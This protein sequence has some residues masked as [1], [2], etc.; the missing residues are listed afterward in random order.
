M[1]VDTTTATAW[2]EWASD[3]SCEIKRPAAL[4]RGLF[5]A[6]C[7]GPLRC[8]GLTMN[9]VFLGFLV[10]VGAGVVVT[11]RRMTPAAGTG[12]PGYSATD[13]RAFALDPMPNLQKGK[14]WWPELVEEFHSSDRARIVLRF[15]VRSSVGPD[16]V[17][18]LLRVCAHEV[19]QR[20]NAHVVYAEALSDGAL[21]GA[22]LW[23]PDG[24]GWSGGDAAAEVWFQPADAS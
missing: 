4:R 12:L 6:V 17:R 21:R 18:E 8:Y 7:A 14:D 22:Y 20:T 11:R 19:A 16:D 9:W 3:R 15:G 1:V 10:A 2:A 13:G 24:R 23:A 5:F